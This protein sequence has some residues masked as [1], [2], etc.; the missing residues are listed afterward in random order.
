MVGLYQPPRSGK[1]ALRL[2]EGIAPNLHHLQWD[3][4]LTPTPVA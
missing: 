2:S 1:D 3:W 4:H